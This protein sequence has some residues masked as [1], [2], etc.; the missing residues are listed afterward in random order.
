[1]A[2]GVL[3]QLFLGVPNL[4][5]NPSRSSVPTLYVN[6]TNQRGN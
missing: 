6:G 3:T 4:T 5:F 2:K 1:L